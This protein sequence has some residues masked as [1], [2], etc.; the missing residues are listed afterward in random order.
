M[1]CEVVKFAYNNMLGLRSLQDKDTACVSVYTL[2]LK[3]DKVHLP[4]FFHEDWL[5]MGNV[6]S[7]QGLEILTKHEY[8]CTG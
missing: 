2:L 7:N 4:I 3:P 1:V 8:T 6:N 5:G